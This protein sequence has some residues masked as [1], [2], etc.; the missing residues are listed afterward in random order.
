MNRQERRAAAREVRKSKSSGNSFISVEAIFESALGRMQAG[1][2]D[3]AEDCC[4]RALALDSEHADTLHLAG[5]LSLQAKRYDQALESIFGAI[6]QDAKPVYFLSLGTTFVSKGDND[7]ALEAFDKAHELG[8]DTADLRLFRG[9]TLVKLNQQARALEDFRKALALRRDHLP[10]LNALAATLFELGRYEDALA[11]YRQA[12]TLDPGNADVCN[13]LA[14]I[15]RSLGKDDE[16]LNWFDRAIALDQLSKEALYGR[17]IALTYLHKLPEALLAYERLKAAYPN[18]FRADV[19]MAHLHL[20]L[21][22]FEMGWA[23][24]EAR[25]KVPSIGGNY[26]KFPYPMW[27]GHEKLKGKNILVVSNEGLGDAIQFI[28]Y[29]P[30]LAN[31][32]ARVILVIQDALYSLLSKFTGVTECIPLSGTSR[33]PNFDFHCS[34]MS[35]PLALGTKLE[36]IPSAIS[37]LP[38]PPRACVRLWNERLGPHDK[39]R[40]GL[41]WSGNPKHVDDHNRSI[42]LREF[43]GLLGASATFVSLQKDIR[44]ADRMAMQHL[45]GLIDF[46]PQLT[47]FVETAALIKCLDLVVTVDTSIAHLAAALGRPTWL[48][49]PYTPDYR[50]LLGRD[51]SP[52]YPT[53][54]LFRQ[55][56]SRDWREVIDRLRGELRSRRFWFA[57]SAISAGFD[58][59]FAFGMP[60]E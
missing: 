60:S 59:S 42:P 34:I 8:L 37:Y 14:K 44:P 3:A 21:G 57:A 19:G 11:A 22:N 4:R 40:I 29:L 16:S 2:Y 55:T 49:L 35:L 9:Q 51:D 13:D 12:H 6:R 56:S 24:R 1:Q 20:L 23:G 31:L 45:P 18:E 27:L 17:A 5:V 58:N 25:W 39:L 28:R 15:F 32:G 7:A 33:L 52:W 38:A 53:M 48:L 30:M 46:S 43:S 47:D 41:A 54:R 50:W 10:T 36:S 26:S